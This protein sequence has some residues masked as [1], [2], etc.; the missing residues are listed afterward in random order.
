MMDYYLPQNPMSSMNGR[1]LAVDVETG[2]LEEPKGIKKHS[3]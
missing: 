3:L 2:F 1:G